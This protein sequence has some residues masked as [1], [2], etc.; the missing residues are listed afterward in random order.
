MEM[1]TRSY[2]DFPVRGTRRT[3]VFAA[4]NDYEN[5]GPKTT[6]TSMSES[7]YRLAGG[8]WSGGG[9]WRMTRSKVYWVAGRSPASWYTS[10]GSHLGTGTIRL[11][12]PTVSIPVLP[13]YSTPS[14]SQLEAD[15]TTAIARVEPTNP[16]FD[17]ST[18]LGEMA[19]EGLPNLPG[20][21]VRDQ[22][23]LAKAAGKDYLNYEFG[24]LPLVR[25]VRDFAKT[26]DQSD[27][28]LNKYQSQSDQV[29]RRSYEWPV[30]SA[31]RV[32]LASHSMQ[33]PIGFFTGGGQSQHVYKRKWFEA[34]FIY[35]V[36][37]GGA[38]NDKFRRYGSYARKLLGVDL[39][40][41]VLWNLSPWSWA[42]DWFSNVGDVMHNISAFGTDG[43]VMR[44][45]FVMC[46]VLREK[47]NW[48][49]WNTRYQ[50]RVE[51]T[52]TKI[53]RSAT[54]YGFGVS[55]DSLSANQVAVIAALGLS[56]W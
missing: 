24:W 43:L 17:L 12:S 47:R 25:G 48:G 4:Y 41:E 15:G 51:I 37:A 53:R 6:E 30:E 20:H 39:S 40:P 18:F 27:K 23:R 52:E 32:D 14:D 22:T 26:V 11:E 19:R 16:A 54:P 33:P 31:D 2:Y 28:I 29:I 46:H 42:A 3:S 9:P 55:F 45:G 49:V 50:T 44:N 13:G 7:H 56:R 38:L 8:R 5:F 1:R 21:V 35:H 34:D 10:G 36:P